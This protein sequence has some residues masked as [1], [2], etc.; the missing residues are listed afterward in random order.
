MSL[1]THSMYQKHILR[2]LNFSPAA[3]PF[4]QLWRD[5]A[6]A[7]NGFC[8]IFERPGAYI[9]SVADYHIPR[10]FSPG[11]FAATGRRCASAAS[12]K[13][14]LITNWTAA[15]QDLPRRFI[16][17]FVS[18]AFAESK[19]GS[20]VT[21]AA[22][23]NWRSRSLISTVSS[24]W[25]HNFPCSTGFLPMSPKMCSR[26]LSLRSCAKWRHWP[27]HK[28][29]R[30]C[31]WREWCCNVW[32]NWQRRRQK[33]ISHRRTAHSPLS[34]ASGG[35]RFRRRTTRPSTRRAVSSPSIPKSITP[36]PL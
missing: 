18:R 15:G 21:T 33:F 23:S 11:L 8:Y 6:A 28:R 5:P 13:A 20:A 31:A 16:F 1:T 26:L 24:P 14:P 3:L 17:S 27:T 22:A 25:P 35:C 29:S 36:S 32:A 34:L 7:E 4:G 19:A 12:T 2:C 10:P 9:L 30:R